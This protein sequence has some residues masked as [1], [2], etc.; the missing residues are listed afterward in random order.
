MQ[1]LELGLDRG[2]YGG[3]KPVLVGSK[4]VEIHQIVVE[5]LLMVICVRKTFP[6]SF[7]RVP[8]VHSPTT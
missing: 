5:F 7:C 6:G 3:S 4:V 1:R 8:L 2:A